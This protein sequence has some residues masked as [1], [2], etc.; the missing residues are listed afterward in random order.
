MMEKIT[1]C[2]PSKNNLRYLKTCLPSI[3]INASRDDHDIIIFVD[4]D[5]DG[6]IEWLEQ[7]QILYGYRYY[8]NPKLN[9]ELYGIGKAYDHCVFWAETDI[10][11]IFHAD[12]M[13]GQDA[14]LNAWKHLNRGKV[15]CATRIEPPLHPNAGEKILEDYGVWPEE[16]DEDGFDLAVGKYQM[17]YEG[18]T[19]TGMFAPWMIYK[20]DLLAIGGHDPILKSAREDSDIF[21]R[22]KLYG[23]ELIQSWDSL[24][25]H[26]TGRGGQFQ[27]GDTQVKDE[28]W[29]KLMSN[30]TKEFIRKWGSNVK[31]TPMLDPIISPKYDIG[32]VMKGGYQLLE[33][34]EPWCSTIYLKEPDDLPLYAFRDMISLYLDKEQ[35]NTSTDLLKKIIDMTFWSGI[36]SNNILVNIDQSTFT[37]E[38]YN[39]IQNLSEIIDQSGEIGKFNVG[40]MDIEI[41]EMNDYKD[42]LIKL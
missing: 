42:K 26:L 11:M 2:I 25:Y 29:Q 3:R 33:A 38:D 12:M 13:L 10:C 9:E 36:P 14:D 39:I 23:Y 17:A 6:T 32:I 24:V 15:V 34:L 31:H 30:S 8:I 7:N 5:N 27:T 19:T 20:E 41:K 40:N 18:K 16:F 4:A 1:F 28:E 21:N 37:Q 22:F 35:P